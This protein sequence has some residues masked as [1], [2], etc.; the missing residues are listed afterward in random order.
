MD[1]L[2]MADSNVFSKRIKKSV[3][4]GGEKS[5]KKSVFGL[6]SG[7]ENAEE[8]PQWDDGTIDFSVDPN[9]WEI[10]GIPKVNFPVMLCHMCWL[11]SLDLMNV[12][13][14]ALSCTDRPRC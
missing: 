10:L 8:D 4:F 7:A 11:F 2:E 13:H 14:E 12:L 1:Q 5:A 6:D 9:M 3:A